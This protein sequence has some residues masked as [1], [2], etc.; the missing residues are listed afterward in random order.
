M[1]RLLPAFV[2]A[3]VVVACRTAPSPPPPAAP[4][5]PLPPRVALP[6]APAPPAAPVCRS[7]LPFSPTPDDAPPPPPA[8][9]VG[10]VVTRACDLA[11]RALHRRLD[12]IAGVLGEG[13]RDTVLGPLARCYGAGE[14][15]WTFVVERGA[16]RPP[17]EF[18]ERT[19][20]LD[21]RPIYLSAD[22]SAPR[23]G[24]TL[25]LAGST[26]VFFHAISLDQIGVF[27][28]D[29]DGR[30]ELYLHESHEQHEN[31]NEVARLERCWTFNARDVAVR[32]HAPEAARA[33][34]IADVDGDGRPDLVLR[35][36]W[37]DVGPCGLAD[38]DFPG[39][40]LLRHSRP[41][42]TFAAD[43][44]AAHGFIAHQCR[45]RPEGLI[46]ATTS[47]GPDTPDTQP[48]YR[49]ACARWWGRAADD[50]A[51][52][53]TRTYPEVPDGGD[54]PLPCFPRAELLRLAHI[55]PPL[56]FRLTCD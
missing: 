47:D 40:L 8:A 34:R 25:H 15:A 22:G 6:V 21:V 9:P 10:P 31:G 16:L 30:G 27:D 23:A 18:H 56:P 52:E 32:E 44:A 41:D 28:W 45:E 19:V 3:T 13:W 39:P 14:G 20:S 49:V 12:P 7:A 24:T 2:A 1:R 55:D 29:G 11:V 54:A 51:A 17:D 4:V 36:P 35:S 26:G 46:P 37:V 50:V 38:I 53:V 42:G 33:V 5:A 48:S 43:D